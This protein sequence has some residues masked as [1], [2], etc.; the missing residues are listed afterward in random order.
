MRSAVSRTQGL[1]K[2]GVTVRDRMAWWFR[3]AVPVCGGVPGAG[4]VTVRERLRCRA[5]GI[6]RDT[7]SC[8]AGCA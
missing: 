7:G 8:K 5:G 4:A 1:V 2:V 3:G 6:A